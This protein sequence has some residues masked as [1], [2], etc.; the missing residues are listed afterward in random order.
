M[1]NMTERQAIKRLRYEDGL[2]KAP[3]DRNGLRDVFFILRYDQ[4]GNPPTGANALLEGRFNHLR[5]AEAAARVHLNYHPTDILDIIRERES[6]DGD[7]T[8]EGDYVW[9]SEWEH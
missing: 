6:K 1:K 2:A 3:F 5:F 7:I 9:S 8:A 4:N